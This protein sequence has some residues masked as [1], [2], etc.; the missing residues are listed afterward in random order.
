[1]QGSLGRVLPDLRGDDVSYR[2]QQRLIFKGVLFLWKHAFSATLAAS[3][4]RALGDR[5]WPAVKLDLSCVEPQ[6]KRRGKEGARFL[7]AGMSSLKEDS[8]SSLFWQRLIQELQKPFSDDHRPKSGCMSAVQEEV[9]MQRKKEDKKDT[10]RIV[11]RHSLWEMMADFYF[12]PSVFLQFLNFLQWRHYSCGQKNI[13]IIKII[14]PTLYS[15]L[16]VSDNLHMLSHLIL[17]VT[18]GYKLERFL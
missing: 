1:M 15:S 12:L 17:L 16:H 13:V 9:C 2:T 14:V 18:L 4:F 10:H 6:R 8:I 7:E 5:G 11:S 3:C